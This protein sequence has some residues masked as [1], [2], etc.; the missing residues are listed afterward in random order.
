[1]GPFVR[2]NHCTDRPDHVE[3]ARDAPLIEGMDLNAAAD[4]IGGDVRLEIREGQD[5]IRPQRD[6]L[7]DVA[8]VKALTRGFSRRA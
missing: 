5:E 2:T 6:D 7:V 3:N 4:E 8:E 1:V